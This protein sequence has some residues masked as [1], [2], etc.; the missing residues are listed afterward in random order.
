[1][2]TI[3]EQYELITRI[4]MRI[5]KNE[6]SPIRYMG[7]EDDGSNYCRAYTTTLGED[8]DKMVKLI[9]TEMKLTT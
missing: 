6:P 4:S 5:R 2:S 3:N 7:V 9:E 1:M 8:L